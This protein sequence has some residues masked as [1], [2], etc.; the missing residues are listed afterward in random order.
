MSLARSKH[1]V[2]LLTAAFWAG[3]LPGASAQM[4]G[5]PVERSSPPPP[6]YVAAPPAPTAGPLSF[7]AVIGSGYSQSAFTFDRNMLQA[8]DGFFSGSDPETRRVLAG[9]NSV[10]VR[11]YH[12]HDF[13]RY[14]TSALAAIDGQ[15]RGA[16]WKH[17][18]N[19]SGKASANIT[20][21]WLHF[22]GGN[23]NNVM[24]LTRGDRNMSVITVECILRPLDLLHL[25]GHFG[26]PKVDEGAV[27]VP[28]P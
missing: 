27:M 1:V 2:L 21:L 15:L 10:T 23:I 24:V 19:G 13:A 14:D 28:A 9:L 18:V 16:G 8:A 25:S 7:D 3:L 11:N 4:L 20:D 17:L 22:N 26:I 12:A 6:P 5:A